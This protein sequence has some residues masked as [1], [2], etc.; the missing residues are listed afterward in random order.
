MLLIVHPV[1]WLY[2][3]WV[4]WLNN[5]HV[6]RPVKFHGNRNVKLDIRISQTLVTEWWQTLDSSLKR[7]SRRA[8]TT[9][10]GPWWVIICACACTWRR[11][12]KHRPSVL[13]LQPLPGEADRPVPRAIPGSHRSTISIW[14]TSQVRSSFYKRDWD[15]VH[16]LF[17]VINLILT[18]CLTIIINI[19][20]F[21]DVRNI[22]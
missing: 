20:F 4:G 7:W 18:T 21:R 22:L 12:V 6:C 9:A 2:V 8:G 17:A 11:I 10:A 15:S 19:Y 16:D 5:V 14:R 1:R 3:W 13:D